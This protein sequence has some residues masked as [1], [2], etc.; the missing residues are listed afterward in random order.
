[1]DSATPE[2][3][4]IGVTGSY[5]YSPIERK[6]KKITFVRC[7]DNDFNYPRTITLSYPGESQ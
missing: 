2:T 5:T 1:M 6:I 4:T 3:I 7:P